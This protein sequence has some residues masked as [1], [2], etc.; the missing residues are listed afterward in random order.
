MAAQTQG[1]SGVAAI[2]LIL[3]AATTQLFLTGG[4]DGQILVLILQQDAT[5][6]RLVTSG[7]IPGIGVLDSAALSDTIYL[8]VYD[9]NTNA[10]VVM[11]V[12]TANDTI[13]A[14]QIA[15]SFI[16]TTAP[17]SDFTTAGVSLLSLTLPAGTY[18][19]SLNAI[20]TTTLSGNSVSAA[21]LTIGYTDA[22]GAE[23]KTN[24]LSA[25]T[26]GGNVSAVYTFTSTGTAPITL[27]GVA[28]T[29][30][31][32]AGVVDVSAVLERIA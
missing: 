25:I 1:V 13:S 31:P 3:A 29:G 18:R 12:A 19:F 28:T 30:N 5:G 32:T 14:P 4:V 10:W 11:S 16:N 7:N 17:F 9:A 26:A 23:T 8:L 27:T 6:G 22:G 2:R 21:G 20:V 15:G 24:A